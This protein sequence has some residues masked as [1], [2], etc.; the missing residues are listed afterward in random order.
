MPN[1]DDLRIAK[2]GATF[3]QDGQPVWIT[4][5]DVGHKDSPVV[6]AHAELFEPLVL[7]YPA[8]APPAPAE[9]AA[10]VK[11]EASAKEELAVKAE[12]PPASGVRADQRG[13][14]TRS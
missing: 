4:I 11:E 13:A 8:P 7:R 5:G 3:D 9:K 10:P 6:A 1:L 2:Q 12:T 14:R